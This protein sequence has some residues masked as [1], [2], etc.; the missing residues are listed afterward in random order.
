MKIDSQDKPW[1]KQFWFYCPG[2]KSHHIFD[3]RNDG[4]RPNW[5]FNGNLDKPTFEP[6]LH[7]VGRCHLRLIDGKLHFASDSKHHL[8]G[9]VVDLPDLP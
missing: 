1:G 9:K 7:Y 5:R 6:S 4:Q 3:V 2:C 8:A